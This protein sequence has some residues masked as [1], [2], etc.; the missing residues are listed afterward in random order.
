MLLTVIF[1]SQIT[2]YVAWLLNIY[3]LLGTLPLFIQILTGTV[4]VDTH[5]LENTKLR[6]TSPIDR[7]LSLP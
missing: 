1:P 2:F 5:L 4:S 7:P 6:S 3:S